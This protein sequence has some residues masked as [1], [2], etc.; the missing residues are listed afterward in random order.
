MRLVLTSL[1]LLFGFVAC[2]PVETPPEPEKKSEAREKAVVANNEVKMDAF[3]A[4][5]FKQLI[6]NPTRSINTKVKSWWLISGRP[7]ANPASKKCRS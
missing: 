6:A 1:I 5:S 3:F 2:K 4:S 7:G